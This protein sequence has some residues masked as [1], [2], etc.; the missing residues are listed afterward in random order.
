M[1]EQI[2]IIVEDLEL[3][4]G[5][6][7]DVAKELKEVRNGGLRG[8]ILRLPRGGREA[9]ARGPCSPAPGLHC[10]PQAPLATSRRVEQLVSRLGTGRSLAVPRGLRLCLTAVPGDRERDGAA[11]MEPRVPSAVLLRVRSCCPGC[12]VALPGD[13][14]PRLTPRRCCVL[15]FFFSGRPGCL[16]CGVSAA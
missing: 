1:K 13:F 16:S 9:L 12:E 15:F 14:L 5:D 11:W 7:K 3:V 6:L 8:R 4:L 10:R 2:K